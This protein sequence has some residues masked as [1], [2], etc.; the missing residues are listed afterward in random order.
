[1]KVW[2][3]VHFDLMMVLDRGSGDESSIDPGDIIN[4]SKL[5]CNPSNSCND[6]LVNSKEKRI[7][8]ILQDP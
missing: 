2:T 7:L 8:L 3:K 6:I 1:M 5:Q 4:I